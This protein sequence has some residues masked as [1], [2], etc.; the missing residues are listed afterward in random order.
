VIPPQSLEP[1]ALPG[2]IAPRAFEHRSAVVD[3][4]YAL[5]SFIDAP[6]RAATLTNPGPAA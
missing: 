4:T 3:I 2:N 5:A 6:R 1:Q